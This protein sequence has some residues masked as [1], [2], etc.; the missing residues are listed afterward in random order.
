LA[1]QLYY[2]AFGK[3]PEW[4]ERSHGIKGILEYYAEFLNMSDHHAIINFMKLLSRKNHPKGH[5]FCPC[6]SKRR[7]R[8][9]H[10]ELLQNLRYKIPWID[11]ANDLE[12]I[13]KAK[14]DV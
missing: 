1:W 13:K 4:G 7:I 6:G 9:C 14:L 5:E 10:C 11:V 3:P 2:D 8:H 12:L